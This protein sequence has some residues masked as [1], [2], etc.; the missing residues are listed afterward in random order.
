MFREGLLSLMTNI[1]NIRQSNLLEHFLETRLL[2]RSFY[3]ELKNRPKLKAL[4][5]LFFY[6]DDVWSIYSYFE[7]GCRKKCAR[8]N[9]ERKYGI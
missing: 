5:L 4:V 2:F 3:H 6:G 8:D 7:K 9:P 1:A